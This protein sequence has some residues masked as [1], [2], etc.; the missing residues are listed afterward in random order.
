MEKNWIKEIRDLVYKAMDKGLKIKG[1]AYPWS[2]KYYQIDIIKENSSLS[3][4]ISVDNGELHITTDKGYIE[5]KLNLSEREALELESLILSIKEYNQ[6]M[7][8]SEFNNFFKEEE[9]KT[10]GIDDLNDDD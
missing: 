7:A 9:A 6:D 10:P 4:G 8:I 5:I 1:D 3:L 2:E